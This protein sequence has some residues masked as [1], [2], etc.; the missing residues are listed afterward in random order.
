MSNTYTDRTTNAPV[1]NFYSSEAQLTGQ[2]N[3][4]STELHM[5]PMGDRIVEISGDNT[6]GYRI[7]SSGW[8]EQWGGGSGVA[9]NSGQGLTGTVTLP[10]AFAN[11]T[12]SI[13][14]AMST[15]SYGN[16]MGIGSRTT[17]T[18]TWNKN[19]YSG[20]GESGRFYWYACGF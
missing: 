4:L 10:H 16:A 1:L 7:W 5:I 3:P 15:S 18:F 19:T 6:N 13:V 12:Y 2:A 14:T 8:I 20:S 17:T 9:Y 11:A